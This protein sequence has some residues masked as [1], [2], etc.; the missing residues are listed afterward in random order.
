MSREELLEFCRTL[1]AEK[2]VAAFTYPALKLVPHLYA[3]LY[4][5]GLPQKTLLKELRLGDEYKRYLLAQP[6][7]Y[8]GKLRQRWSWDVVVE[9]A[10]AMKDQHG[11]LPPALW[12]QKNG[13]AS[14]IQALYGMGRTWSDLREAVGD[15]T[16]GNFVQS[17]ND[18]RWLSH[19]EASL[20]NF[21]YARGIEHKKG[22]RYPKSFAEYSSARYAIYDLHFRNQNGEWV[23]VEVWATGPTGTMRKNTLRPAIRRKYSTNAM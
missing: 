4:D 2:G 17:R 7:K 6:G 11:T 19:A 12:F 23:D 3:N 15:I 21:L 20:S 9:R 5:K 13:H 16:G 18:V 10:R 1:Y 14:L 8:G 22:E